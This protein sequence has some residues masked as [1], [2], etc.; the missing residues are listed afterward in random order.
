MEYAGQLEDRQR[1]TATCYL[2][3]FRTDP[4]VS[5]QTVSRQSVVSRAS[6]AS[7]VS[8]VQPSC[9]MQSRDWSGSS[10]REYIKT[11]YKDYIILYKDIYKD[12]YKD[13]YKD[14]L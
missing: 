8:P 3:V 10:I 14:N 2:A 7:R 12:V 6:R 11:V 13:V 9:S 1:V 5:S 4:R